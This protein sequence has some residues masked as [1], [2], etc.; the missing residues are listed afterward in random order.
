MYSARRSLIPLLFIAVLLA[1][2][3]GQTAAGQPTSD[4]NGTDAAGAQTMGAAV[5]Q[6]QTAG[7]PTVTNTPLPTPSPLATNTALA[8]P[9]PLA[10]ATQGVIFF[11]SPTPTG[12]F[13]TQTPSSSSLAYGCLN[14]SFIR[15][16]TYEDGTDVLP[17]TTFTKTW[18]V[19]NNGTCDWLYL[20]ELVFSS[21]DRLGGN[22]RR[23]SVRVPPGEWR[24]LSV[25]LDAPTQGGTYTGYWRL[26]DGSGHLFGASLKVS[27]VVRSP[28][29]TPSYP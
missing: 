6:T 20:H 13:Y 7:A 15:H 17:G 27:I 9:S 21:G 14:M 28:T 8:L 1:S 12:T 23:L 5:L 4:V 26:S 22:S 18:Q 11:A 24:Q 19:S 3:G 25:E 2:C 29:R 16:V 10:S